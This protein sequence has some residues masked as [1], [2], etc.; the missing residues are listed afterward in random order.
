MVFI[1]VEVV[2]LYSALS[3]VIRCLSGNL[4]LS[5]KGKAKEMEEKMV[6]KLQEDVDMDDD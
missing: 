6:Q 4:L 5:S 1:L 3:I 2:L